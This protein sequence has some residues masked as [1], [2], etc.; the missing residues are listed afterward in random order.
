MTYTSGG[1]IQASD[2]NDFLGGATSNVSGSINSIW[3]TGYGNAGYGQTSNL[4]NVSIGNTVTA[5]QWN[6]LTY[7]VD[8]VS[9]HQNNANSNVSLVSV[10]ANIT[11]QSNLSATMSNLYTNRLVAYDIGNIANYNQTVTLRAN[12]NQSFTGNISYTVQFSSADQARYF[13]NAGGYLN[14][15]Y[16]SFT[17]ALS[18]DRGTSIQTLAQTNF[19]SKDMKA[20][21]FGARTG[22]GGTL[23]TDTTTGAAGYYGITSTPTTKIRIDS[24]G[25]YGGDY[26]LV[27]YNNSGSNGSNGGNGTNIDINAVIFSST[28]GSTDPEDRLDVNLT[29]RLTVVEPEVD[30]LTNSWGAITVNS[31]SSPIPTP[32]PPLPG[33][34]SYTVP[35]SYNFVVPTGATSILVSVY[36]A[37]GGGGAP[38]FP[39]GDG[40]VGG[41][42]SSGGYIVNSAVPV[43]SGESLTVSVGDGGLGGVYVFGAQIPGLAGSDSYIQRSGSDLLRATGGGGGGPGLG[44]NGPAGSPNGVQGQDPCNPGNC[45]YGYNAPRAGGN[46]GTGYGIGGNGGYF[47]G[48]ALAGTAGAVVIS[49]G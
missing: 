18:N 47:G 12:G 21:S 22:S 33:S 27:N 39:G 31:S 35:G 8:K 23:I 28:V 29:M 16:F 48:E 45:G 44:G 40:W 19:A 1:L 6:A 9:N 14:L 41:G 13:F 10:G 42:G 38:Y 11:A 3:S 30:N 20:N 17:N 32:L 7:V 43:T 5:E 34:Q 26:F 25:F 24:D 37:G 49:W 36:G 4:A 15:Q 2:Y 46:N